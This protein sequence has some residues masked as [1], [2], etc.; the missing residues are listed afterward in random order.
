MFAAVCLGAVV[1]VPQTAGATPLPGENGRIVLMS[2][3]PDQ[4]HASLF[5][6]PVPFSSGGGTLSPAI[7][8]APSL[9]DL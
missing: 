7:R 6:L 4:A 3:D 2:Y 5:L 1:A 9:A 8:G